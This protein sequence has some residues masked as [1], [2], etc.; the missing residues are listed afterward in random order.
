MSIAT[1]IATIKQKMTDFKNELILKI[2]LPVDHAPYADVSDKLEGYTPDQVIQQLRDQVTVHT[3][4]LGQGVHKVDLTALGTYT[5]PQFDAKIDMLMDLNSGVPFS[6]Y[7]D[8]EYLPPGITGSFESG[9]SASPYGNF[10]MIMEDNGTLVMLRSGSDGD[11][12][13]LYYSYLRN[14]DNEPD[15]T[16]QIVTT[17]TKYSPAF[18]P[19]D[20]QGYCILNSTQSAIIGRLVNK[21]DGKFNGFYLALTN[22]T[23]DQ[24]KHT[25]VVLPETGIINMSIE[26]TA[27]IDMPVAFVAGQWVYILVQKVRNTDPQMGFR[28]YRMPLANLIAG[29]YVTPEYMTG[30]TIN[31]GVAG[32]VGRTD[33]TLFDNLND[34]FNFTGNPSAVR[35]G[36][37]NG[38]GGMTVNVTDQGVVLLTY[39]PYVQIYGIDQAVQEIGFY[40]TLHLTL[41]VVNKAVDVSAYYNKKIQVRYDSVGW[42]FYNA[43][44]LPNITDNTQLGS[45]GYY[46]GYT[47]AIGGQANV[48]L[49]A[50][51]Y[52]QMWSFST[53]TYFTQRTVYRN[54]FP[55]NSLF[56]NV[57]SG[58]TKIASRT[59]WGVTGRF[60]SPLSQSF[61]NHANIGDSAVLV[62]NENIRN[63]GIAYYGVRC[64]LEGAGN[65]QYSSITGNYAFRGF[66][67]TVNRTYINDLNPSGN[68]LNCVTLNEGDSGMDTYFSMARFSTAVP[69]TRTQ[70]LDVNLQGSGTVTC[71]GAVLDSL[72]AQVTA[73]LNARGYAFYSASYA[74]IAV[75]LTVPQAYGDMPPFVV[76]QF[77][78]SDRSVY[79]AIYAVTISGSR[80]NVTGASL[81]TGSFAIIQVP[82][83]G[84]GGGTIGTGIAIT[85]TTIAGQTC[86]RRVSGGFAIGLAAG[87]IYNLFGD[88]ETGIS[89]C[90]YSTSTGVFSYTGH[91]WNYYAAAPAGW[92][93]FPT[94]GMYMT[95]VSEF[96]RGVIDAGTKMIGTLAVT[97]NFHTQNPNDTLLASMKDPNKALIFVSQKIV[98]AWTIYFSDVTPAM[99][100]G[101][102]TLVQPLTYN[103]TPGTDANKTFYIWLVKTGTTFS[104]RVV[105]SNPAT[106]VADSVIYL[107]YVVTTVDGI[108]RI[109]VEK[110]V[111]V[112]GMVLAR[113]SQGSAIPLTS[114]TPNS[115]GRLNWK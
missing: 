83:A 41:D 23:F 10:G 87:L 62:S 114:G 52:N 24:T 47:G 56:S 20:R 37:S 15:L 71:P 27:A 78:R 2:D 99:L 108:Q 84:G 90:N 115:Y 103:L 96:L 59:G 34:A 35:G 39:L 107:G 9:S 101:L 16:G 92:L 85:P 73:N 14:A 17:N 74:P 6:F 11:S 88:G 104:Y 95:L 38:N 111:A 100:D 7:G 80:Q 72:R 50:T 109:V 1:T 110:R 49:Y 5:G 42:Y 112:G 48:C 55:V 57:M 60:G 75:E 69:P 18:F 81:I 33:M 66:N 82:E 36:L 4:K 30:W 26:G 98:S 86:I 93:N 44:G 61:R 13:G 94:R 63:G 113:N 45:S 54:K 46:D 97:N 43:P 58:A 29:N 77:I 3:S 68:E 8:R 105:D 76:A 67:P 31:R 64:M 91:M 89:A 102:Y 12:S 106:P 51:K 79:Q 65:Y 53:T 40:P 70:R 21:S 22:N 28:V 32:V 25:G 19:A